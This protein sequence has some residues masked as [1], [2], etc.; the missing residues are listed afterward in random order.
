MRRQT[1]TIPDLIK[2]ITCKMKVMLMA[3]EIRMGAE[4]LQL[5]NSKSKTGIKYKVHK[6]KTVVCLSIF[7]LEAFESWVK[8]EKCYCASVT[9]H[10]LKLV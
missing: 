1:T 10:I 2:E 6:T 8:W 7:L 5:A 4:K 9:K 3:E